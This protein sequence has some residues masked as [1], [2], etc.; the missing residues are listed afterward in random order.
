[1]ENNTETESAVGTHGDVPNWPTNDKSYMVIV[2][3]HNKL[4]DAGKFTPE[5]LP[6][7]KSITLVMVCAALGKAIPM[8]YRL[9]TKRAKGIAD[10]PTYVREYTDAVCN[11]N[12]LSEKGKRIVE[13]VKRFSEDLGVSIQVVNVGLQKA[14]KLWLS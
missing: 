13:P 10:H 3:N 1:M 6:G 5:V 12:P 2:N 7:S 4:V 14:L 11:G 8:K 9:D